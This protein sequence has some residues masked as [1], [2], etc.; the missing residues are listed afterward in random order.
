MRRWEAASCAP[1]PPPLTSHH[2]L[3]Q[4]TNEGWHWCWLMLCLCVLE[5]GQGEGRSQVGPGGGEGLCS[6]TEGLQEKISAEDLS[7][8]A[9]RWDMQN[10][11]WAGKIWNISATVVCYLVDLCM[12]H[13]STLQVTAWNLEA[14]LDTQETQ[15]FNSKTKSL[16]CYLI[17]NMLLLSI[18]IIFLWEDT[19]KV[20]QHIKG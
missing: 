9:K 16:W 3:L 8:V 15:T 13:C 17:T 2:L 6:F 20:P 4:V 1:H 18:I 19:V 5:G 12:I 11:G 7:E 14:K 10:L